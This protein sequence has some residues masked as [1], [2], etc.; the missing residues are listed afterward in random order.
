V[1]L[2]ER[3][4]AW[5]PAV[6]EVPLFPPG[7]GTPEVVP[8]RALLPQRWDDLL[9]EHP[10]PPQQVERGEVYNLAT[11][12]PALIAESVVTPDGEEPLTA[13]D[14]ADLALSGRITGPQ[15]NQLFNA[16]WALNDRSPAADL[17][18]G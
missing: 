6:A 13:A 1:G 4:S 17:G 3:L 2:K 16:A 18:K 10:P 9:G 7:G 5:E 11:F 12:R 15:Y 8:L 14:W